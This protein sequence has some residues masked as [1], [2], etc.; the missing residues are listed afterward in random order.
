VLWIFSMAYLA[1]WIVATAVVFVAGNR[2]CEPGLPISYR[3]TLSVA[4]GLIWPLLLIGAV[5]FTSMAM[6]SSAEQFAHVKG[7]GYPLPEMDA[8]QTNGDIVPIR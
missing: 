3:L 2:L 1:G 6:Y 5:E 8:E 7:S 4:A